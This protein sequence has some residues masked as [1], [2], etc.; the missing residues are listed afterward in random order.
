MWLTLCLISAFFLGLYDVAKKHAVHGNAVFPVLFF[1][2][3]SGSL[4]TLP[5][6]LLSW[7]QPEFARRCCLYIPS[8]PVS[9]HL[10]IVIKSLIVGTSWVLSYFGLKHLPITIA[11]PLRA[12]APLFTVLGAVALFGERPTPSQWVG[13]ILILSAYLLYSLSARKTGKY[14]IGLIWV[15]FMILSAVT[16]A[17]SAGF[18]KVLLQSK[19]LPPLFVLSWFLF[20]LSII[21]GIIALFFWYPRRSG[22]TP[23]YFRPGILFV[24]ILLVI[25]DTVYMNALADPD[26]KLALVS[27]IRRSNVIISFIG[28]VVLFHEG[29]IRRKIIP[30]CGILAGLFLIL[31]F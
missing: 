19:E 21:F 11:T 20:Y 10:L 15:L 5:I 18:D 25:T 12:T 22:L 7:L 17:G 26:A 14:R 16:G 1:S 3:L 13:I 29:D 28:G 23:F 27:S 2:T 24:G 8:L 9:V 4:C 30:F 6:I 31:R